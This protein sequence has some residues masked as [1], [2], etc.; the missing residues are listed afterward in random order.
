MHIVVFEDDGVE[1]LSPI[2]LGRAAYTIQCGG[3]CLAD[4]LLAQDATVH[5]VVR[6]YLAEWQAAEHS[7]FSATAA[8]V[9]EPNA[10][11]PQ[12]RLL[13]NARFVPCR[14]NF[15]VL[16]QLLSAGV[17]GRVMD[18]GSVAAIL[19]PPG[20]PGWPVQLDIAALTKYLGSD[21]VQKLPRMEY[22]MQL[23][24]DPSDL[25]RQHTACFSENLERR[26]EEGGYRPVRDGVYVA[27]DVDLAEMIDVET[28]EGPIVIEGGASI[29]PFAC[30]RGPL[31]LGSCGRIN[32]Q[33]VIRP[34]V[35]IGHMSKVGGE[36]EASIIEPFSNKQHHGYLGHSYLGRWVNLGAGTCN[37]NLKNT[38]GS[39]RLEI[40][41]QRIDTGL[42]FMGCVVGDF[43]KTAINTAIFTG[44]LIGCGSMVYGSVTTNVPSFVNYAR[45]FG[46]VTEQGPEIVALT[47][48]RVFLRRGFQQQPWQVRLLHRMYELASA[49]RQLADR[50]VSL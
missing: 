35:S 48:K 10:G 4:W 28:K 49:G 21:V 8:T 25:I 19:L 7:E 36:V 40:G 38:Y 18:R 37:S 41:E 13:V 27:G 33:A 22:Q 20:L 47:Q 30:V 9:P 24:H 29:R 34:G 14:S 43:T 11:Q 39:I 12:Q 26:I 23:L 1:R 50:P 17:P 46:E 6:P 3:E 44:K 16:R 5:G 32:E 2:T 15:A 45:S 42:Q 31:Y